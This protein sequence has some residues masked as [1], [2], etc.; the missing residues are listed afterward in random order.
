MAERRVEVLDRERGRPDRR[1][2]DG[3]RLAA[4]GPV[5]FAVAVLAERGDLVPG[6]ENLL[7]LPAAVAIARGRP[8]AAGAEVAI[9]VAPEKHRDAAPAIDEPAGHRA[10]F[11]VV[12]ARRSGSVNAPRSD[13]DR[14]RAAPCTRSFHDAPTEIGARWR[15]ARRRSRSPPARPGP[16]SPMYRSPVARSKLNRHGLRRPIAQISGRPAP[17]CAYTLSGGIAY[18][19]R[20]VDVDAQHL[21]QQRPAG[22]ARDCQGRCRCRRRPC[23]CTG[24]RRARSAARRRC[25]LRTAAQ[26]SRSSLRDAGS[27]RS[28]IRRADRET[29]RSPSRRRRSRV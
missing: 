2:G 8:H 13:R 20:A 22:P 16:T 12:V 4:V 9:H 1:P 29:T 17:P 7:G 24:S 26:S 11:A 18:G 28:R 5:D 23:R 15:A 6:D 14:R 3:S 19:A 25:D 21:A 10:A 27:A